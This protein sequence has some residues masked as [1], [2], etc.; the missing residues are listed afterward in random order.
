MPE[1]K[2]DAVPLKRTETPVPV[3]RPARYYGGAGWDSEVNRAW[4]MQVEGD[5]KQIVPKAIQ[6]TQSANK[7]NPYLRIQA[8]PSWQLRKLAMFLFSPKVYQLVLEPPLRDL[9]D[10]YCQALREG[11]PWKAG[12]VRVRGYCSF[13]LVVLAQ[14]P[15]SLTKV[16][17]QL[18][19][20]SQ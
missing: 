8:P 15:I 14:L 6:P 20:A 1:R 16:L 9:Y 11:S 4:L 13:W 10:E 5:P 7:P 19:R 2:E 17:H 18:W 3:V 12:W